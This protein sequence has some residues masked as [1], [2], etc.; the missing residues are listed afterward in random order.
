MDGVL[1]SGFWHC[2]SIYKENDEYLPLLL[3]SK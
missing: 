1:D 3:P 2:D